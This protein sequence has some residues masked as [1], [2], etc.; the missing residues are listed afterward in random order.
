MVSRDQLTFLN[1]C[2][3]NFLVLHQDRKDLVSFPISFMSSNDSTSDDPNVSGNATA[4]RPLTRP[5]M[6]MKT[7]GKAANVRLGRYK[8]I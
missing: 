6:P 2:S 3:L 4:K 8:T 1:E 5:K 7:R